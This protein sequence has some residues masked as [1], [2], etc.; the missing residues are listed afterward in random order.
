ML[1]LKESDI[2]KEKPLQIIYITKTLCNSYDNVVCIN[3]SNVGSTQR[4]LAFWTKINKQINKSIL[5]MQVPNVYYAV[6]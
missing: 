2:A 1:S 3:R 6:Q 4:L 5:Q